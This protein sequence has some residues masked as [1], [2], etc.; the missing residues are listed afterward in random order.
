[1]QEVDLALRRF[2]SK[3]TEWH[4]R[5]QVLKAEIL[6]VQ[7]K[8]RDALALLEEDLP[9]SLGTSEVAVQ[10]KYT[11]GSADAS[12]GLRKEADEELAEAE[13]L[14]TSYHPEL[15]GKVALIF[16]TVQFMK[17]APTEAEVAYKKALDLAREEKDQFLEAAAL[18][19]L[20]VATMM[21]GHYDEAVEWNR[22]AAD[23]ARSVG[24]TGSLER[25]LG[26]TGWGYAELGDYENALKFYEQAKEASIKSSLLAEQARWTTSIAWAHQ[27][28]GD[29]T[30]AETILNQALP[31]ARAQDDKGI[32]AQCLNQ[33]AWIAV[34]TGRND[35]AAKYVQEAA[36]FEKKD[37]DSRLAIDALL[38]RGLIGSSRQNYAEAK[39]FFLNVIH[40]PQAVKY[41]QWKAQAELANV[42]AAEA[43]NENAEKQYRLSLSTIEEVRA[44]IQSQELRLTFLFNTIRFYSNFIDFL[45]LQDRVEDALQVAELSRARTLAEGLGLEIKTLSFPLRNFHPQRIAQRRKAMLLDYW[46]GPQQSYLWVITAAKIS[47]F[48]FAKQS[49]VETL[50]N[51]YR[52][53]MQSGK[54]MLAGGGGAGQKLYALL[55]EPAK[56]LIPR[57]AQVIILPDGGLYKLNFEA[58]IVPEPTPHYWIEDVTLTTASSL[59]LLDSNAK[60]TP[61]KEK[62]LLLVGNTEQPNNDFPALAQAPMEMK[63]IEQYFPDSRRIVLEGKQATPT[64]YLESNPGS[65]SYVHFVTHGTASITHPLES[66][67]ILSKEG[68]SYKLYARDI[69]QHHLNA[70]LVTISACDTSGK[71]NISGE[72]L[73]GLSW[74]FLRAGAH[75]VIG[76][77]WEVSDA[78]TPQL[79]DALYGELSQGKDPATAL[80]DAKLAMLHSNANNV[81][82]K[83]FYWAPFQLYAG[84]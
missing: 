31:L 48:T 52:V 18:S 28:L 21:E 19:G 56:K 53:A 42:Y 62:R 65:F 26:N 84:S 14:A 58:L 44:S 32:L 76:A 49:E 45:M 16:G 27:G 9:A 34:G 17:G 38:L 33:L 2:S 51:D 54:D 10:R 80:R 35:L 83:P 11:Q 39:K 3:E 46:L 40:Q 74:A 77:L 50:V 79:M 30:G 69:V 41:Q 8:E 6:D 22:S 78:S 5:F 75:N 70:S 12:I 71:R 67:V 15:L 4:W 13:A 29:D 73:V 55:V 47:V 59:R 82:K 61:R 23:L 7:G 72:G 60:F 57:N 37:P 36:D 24:A 63:N 81:F 25:A 64:A 66:A 1:L 43:Q 68:D 20:G